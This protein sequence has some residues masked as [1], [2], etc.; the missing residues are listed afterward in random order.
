MSSFRPSTQSLII[1]ASIANRYGCRDGLATKQIRISPSKL[2]VFALPDYCPLCC[3]RLLRM[4]FQKPYNFPPAYVLI[5]LDGHQKQMARVALEDGDLP[6]FFGDCADAT[7]MLDVSSLACHDEDTDLDLYG[8]PDFVLR[9][10]D[11]TFAIIDAK[12]AHVK[13]E[14][15][16]LFYAYRLQVNFYA[17]VAGLASPSYTVSR[18]GLLYFQF[19]GMTDTEIRKNFNDTYMW[20]KFKPEYVDVEIDPDTVVIPV[21]NRIRELLDMTE[22]PKGRKGCRDCELIDAFSHLLSDDD[23]TDA[24][25]EYLTRSE[26][27]QFD[28]RRRYLLSTDRVELRSSVMAGLIGAANPNGALRNWWGSDE[29][30]E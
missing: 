1:P 5:E 10:P 9:L 28:A 29:S 12:T 23:L 16:P 2:G 15:S 25:P 7:E 24:A 22:A 21:L 3:Y 11:E 8:K 26:R 13:K 27:Q 20:G 30:V 17:Y 14:G 18:G 19:A 4:R 6:E